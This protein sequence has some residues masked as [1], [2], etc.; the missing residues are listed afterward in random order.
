VEG[1]VRLQYLPRPSVSSTECWSL[2]VTISRAGASFPLA[3][4]FLSLS[5][6]LIF[7]AIFY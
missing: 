7:P 4:L 6:V 3:T 5:L 2:K 1:F